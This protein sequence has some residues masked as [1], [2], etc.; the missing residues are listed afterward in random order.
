MNKIYKVVWSRVKNCYVVVSEIVKNHCGGAGG[1]SA[2]A[3][4]GCAVLLAV[5]ALTG[6]Y[7]I[8][9]A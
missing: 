7:G 2:A 1:Q 9:P 3:V 4:R 5:A 8:G 6:G